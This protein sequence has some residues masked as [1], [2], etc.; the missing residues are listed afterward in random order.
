[1]SNDISR[2][3]RVVIAH[4]NAFHDESICEEHQYTLDVEKNGFCFTFVRWFFA[5]IYGHSKF[6]SKCCKRRTRFFIAYRRRRVTHCSSSRRRLDTSSFASDGALGWKGTAYDIIA[7][8]RFATHR[9][10]RVET[11]QRRGVICVR[12]LRL[13]RFRVRNNIVSPCN[14]LILQSRAED[15]PT[16]DSAILI[17]ADWKKEKQNKKFLVQR[18]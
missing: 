15:N 10:L 4:V 17:R 16:I 9:Y 8:S 12:K 18:I 2:I 7:G 14:R 5:E 6:R 3:P 11:L 1:M 13:S